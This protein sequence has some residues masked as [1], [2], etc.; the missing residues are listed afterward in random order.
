VFQHVLLR[1]LFSV[2]SFPLQHKEQIFHLPD[3]PGVKQ[4]TD[5][6][7][8]PVDNLLPFHGLYGVG[9]LAKDRR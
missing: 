9:K 5:S 8:H 1:S 3:I 2:L 7:A 6:S 4:F